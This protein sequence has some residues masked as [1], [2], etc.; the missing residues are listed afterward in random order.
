MLVSKS[1]SMH[2]YGGEGKV[3]VKAKA[4][5]DLPDVEDF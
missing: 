4:L 5:V 3:K 1:R 2:V